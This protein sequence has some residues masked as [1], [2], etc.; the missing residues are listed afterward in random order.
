[1][2]KQQLRDSQ[3]EVTHKLSEIFQLKTQLRETRTEMRNKEA[4][5]DALKLILQGSRNGRC[6][7]KSSC[8]NEKG[9]EENITAGSSGVCLKGFP[10]FYQQQTMTFH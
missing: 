5:I 1:M 7:S 9:P 4:Q 10:F 6:S 3:A 8:E 2:L